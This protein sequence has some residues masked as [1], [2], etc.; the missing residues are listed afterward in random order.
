[1]EIAICLGKVIE[2]VFHMPSFA[3]VS[4]HYLHVVVHNLLIPGLAQTNW[5]N[6]IACRSGMSV[7]DVVFSALF[8]ITMTLFWIPKF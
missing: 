5:A 8:L 3:P 6:E 4:M 2:M 7:V 1:M